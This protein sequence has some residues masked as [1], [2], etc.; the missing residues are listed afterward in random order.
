MS[1]ID[2][3]KACATM[4][5]PGT[6][7]PE[8]LARALD[9]MPAAELAALWC[10]LQYLGMRDHSEQIW[11][12]ILYFDRL[13]HAAPERAFDLVLGVLGS[14]APKAIKMEL[15][16][17]LMLALIHAHG[18]ALIGRIERE[19]SAK[20]QLRWLLGGAYWWTSDEDLKARLAAFADTESW[21]S[22]ADARDEPAERIDFGALPIPQLAR[23]WVEQKCKPSKDQDA[24]HAALADYERDLLDENPDKI[25]DLIVEILRIETS[26]AVLAF[27]AAGLLE[28]VIGEETVGRIEREAATSGAFRELLCGAWF[29][30][31]PS[32]V[33]RRLEAIVGGQQAR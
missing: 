27:L 14:D 20:P 32:D 31:Q 9:A 8:E 13:P 28:D 15:N 16:S 10:S 18:G 23:A 11:G 30:R 24:N 33:K 6:G 26:A 2:D 3:A 17:K 12:T 22:D 1:F 4:A 19:A 29:S 21:R 25:I 5:I 7:T